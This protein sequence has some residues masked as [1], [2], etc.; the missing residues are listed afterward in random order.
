VPTYTPNTSLSSVV[1][2]VAGILDL[3]KVVEMVAEHQA[4]LGFTITNL[5]VQGGNIRIDTDV[6]IDP[7]Q[8]AHLR[9]S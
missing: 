2:D 3:L 9:I 6:A 7:A 4:G 8:L 1:G 5:R